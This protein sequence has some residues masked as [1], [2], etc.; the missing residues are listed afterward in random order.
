[1]LNVTFTRRLA[2]ALA[3]VF[4]LPALACTANLGGPEAPGDPISVS[5]E[6]AG[7][8]L[9]VLRS[10]RGSNPGEAAVILTQEQLTSYLTFALAEQPDPPIR[11]PQVYLQNGL[12]KVFGKAQGEYFTANA[13]IELAPSVDA[14][15]Q[16]ALTIQSADFGPLPVPES[17]L[18]SLSGAITGAFT[19]GLG[20]LATGI[21]ITNVAIVDGEMAVTG[22]LR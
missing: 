9:E 8:L 10:A 14:N 12:I 20:P 15:G 21:Q 19:G 11:D 7:E 5:T 6:A 18:E 4:V 16:L 1:M 17:L 3:S 22:T 2:L 13:L